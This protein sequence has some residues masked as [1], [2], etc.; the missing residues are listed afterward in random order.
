MK[1]RGNWI[2]PLITTFGSLLLALV[3]CI[4]LEVLQK[5][6]S[7]KCSLPVKASSQGTSAHLSADGSH[8]PA[9]WMARDH[10]HCGAL[11]VRGREKLATVEHTDYLLLSHTGSL[12]RVPHSSAGHIPVAISPSMPALLST[13]AGRVFPPCAPS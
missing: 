11:D 3:L 8:R 2:I 6:L 13:H 5:D 10:T 1:P 12:S 9:N 4:P 7:P